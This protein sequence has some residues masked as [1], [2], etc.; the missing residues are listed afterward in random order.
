MKTTIKIKT[1]TYT[2]RS[3]QPTYKNSELLHLT[4]AELMDHRIREVTEQAMKASKSRRKPVTGGVSRVYPKGGEHMSTDLYVRSYI[5]A[6]AGT[7]KGDDIDNDRL[8]FGP[9]STRLTIPEGVDAD[10]SDQ[11]TICEVDDLRA[12]VTQLERDALCR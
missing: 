5:L 6:N 9:L 1:T 2:L 3:T 4:E 12:R 10:I 11:D 7:Y 8:F